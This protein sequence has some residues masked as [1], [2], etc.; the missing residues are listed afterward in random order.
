VA[1]EQGTLRRGE[2]NISWLRMK[3]T[4]H[5]RRYP[6]LLVHG[7]VA[8][9]ERWFEPE[10]DGFARELVAQG[11]EV[12]A[13]SL[14]GRGSSSCPAA[15]WTAGDMAADIGAIADSLAPEGVLIV[16]HSMGVGYALAFAEEHPE[17]VKAF[18]AGDY[19]PGLIELDPGWVEM[20]NGHRKPEVLCASAAESMYREQ[21]HVAGE[22][23]ALGFTDG[24]WSVDLR[25]G[26]DGF[27]APVL[28]VLARDSAHPEWEA[29]WRP[30]S[31]RTVRWFE[32]PHDIF[33]APA[34][35]KA[36]V[37]FLEGAAPR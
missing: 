12:I 29:L 8:R 35:L 25:P 1:L 18:V 26:L 9:A 19:M 15:G 31:Q 23:G 33:R 28:V 13:L 7:L 27:S 4:S 30:S 3:P 22:R 14:R 34:A 5:R 6:V 20:V 37:D 32:A 36:T 21:D 17:R 2:V 11:F 10:H 24:R 16:A